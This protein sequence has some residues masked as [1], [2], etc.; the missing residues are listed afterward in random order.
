MHCRARAVD[1]PIPPFG[2]FVLLQCYPDRLDYVDGVL[3]YCGDL[4]AAS[5]LENVDA[6]PACAKQ[7]VNLLNIPVDTYRN[8]LTVLGPLLPPPP[9][10][11]R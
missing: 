3:G 6:N 5:G 10:L 2:F 11:Y 8:I 9:L 7:L 4:L 1:P